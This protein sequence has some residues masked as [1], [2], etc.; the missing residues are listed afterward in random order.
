MADQLEPSLMNPHARLICSVMALNKYIE[1]VSLPN[2]NSLRVRL[3]RVR[4]MK[5]QPASSHRASLGRRF[6]THLSH[7]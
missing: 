6:Y 5:L 1:R 3:L 7:A 4:G 2:T